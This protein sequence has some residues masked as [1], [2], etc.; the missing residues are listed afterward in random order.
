MRLPGIVTIALTLLGTQ[1]RAQHPSEILGDYVEV[2]SNRVYGCYCEWSGEAV[3]GG[4]EAILAWDFKA[5]EFRGVSL[6]GV[7][8]VAV[9]IGQSTLSQGLAPRHSVLLIDK[10]AAKEQQE[11][12]HALLRT[13]YGQLLG[14]ILKVHLVPVQFQKDIENT[15]LRAGEIVAV[16][17]RKARLPE[18]AMKGAVHWYDPFIP[19]ADVTLG[20]T[21]QSKY[22]GHDF[23]RQWDV[24]E[25]AITGYYGCFSLPLQ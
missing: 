9:I 11:A 12:A 7:K 19:L 13:L 20:T 21:L 2:R 4:K 24:T 23:D 1:V 18:D 6:A 3:T 22:R 14:E 16:S 8:I 17:M 5:G 10:A 25:H 15:D